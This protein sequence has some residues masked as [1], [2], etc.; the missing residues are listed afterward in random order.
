MLL[1]Q[2]L[3]GDFRISEL[4]DVF[5]A[6][7]LFVIFKTKDQRDSGSSLLVNASWLHGVG[8]TV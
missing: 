1:L 7:F 5:D 2:L 6:L 4:F 3:C 8:Y